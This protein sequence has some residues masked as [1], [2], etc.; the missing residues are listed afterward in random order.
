MRQFITLT[1]LQLI[2]I[3]TGF[4]QPPS[5]KTQQITSGNQRYTLQISG[6]YYEG[7]RGKQHIIL[8]RNDSD[9]LWHD[10]VSSR[11]LLL[12]VVSNQGD[13]A[14]T[15]D[16]III[17]DTNHQ[18]KG[19]FYFPEHETPFSWDFYEGA[20]QGFSSNGTR[21]YLFVFTQEPTDFFLRCFT[22]SLITLWKTSFGQYYPCDIQFYRNSVIVH[23]WCFG[24]RNYVNR[25]YVLDVSGQKLWHHSIDLPKPF[26]GIFKIDTTT[27]VLRWNSLQT[28]G[29]LNLDS[30]LNAEKA[31]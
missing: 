16:S 10:Y 28:T 31:D 11:H 20:V 27:G 3:S 21:F 12:P 19:V 26:K 9:T 2:L 15:S 1:L 13:V 24:M 5:Y 29:H 18:R 23:D 7:F 14:I 17:Y 30:L 25:S 22:D 6:A 8:S 4:C